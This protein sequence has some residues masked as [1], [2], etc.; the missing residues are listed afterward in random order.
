VKSGW[1]GS[2]QRWGAR[3]RVDIPVQVSAQPL[4][5]T[6]GTLK[7]LSLSGALLKADVALQLHALIEVKIKP[8]AASQPAS[9]VIAHVSRKYKDELGLEWCDFAPSVIKDLLRSDSFRLSI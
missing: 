5:A 7:N 3:I 8:P 9:V 2:E 4:T 6:D 1:N